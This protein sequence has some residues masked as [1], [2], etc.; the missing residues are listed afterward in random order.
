M[1]TLLLVAFV[2]AV[3]GLITSVVILYNLVFAKKNQYLQQDDWWL[4]CS[5]HPKEQID[6][7][8]V[9]N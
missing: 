7:K 4:E 2:A 9:L 6:L 3:V 5:V 8:K 1:K